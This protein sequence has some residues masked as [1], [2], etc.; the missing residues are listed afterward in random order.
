[1]K[2][3]EIK[4]NK[5]NRKPNELWIKYK[6]PNVHVIEISKGKRRKVKIT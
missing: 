5:I 6:R 1:M 3:R 2:Q 4:I